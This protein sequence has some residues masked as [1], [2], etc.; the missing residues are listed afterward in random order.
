MEN[1]DSYWT[2]YYKLGQCYVAQSKW[3]DAQIIYENILK[4]DPQNSSIQESIAYIYAMNGKTQEALDLYSKIC[5][6]FPENQNAHENYISI[7]ITN[8]QIDKAQ[9][10]FE[11]YYTSGP[12]VGWNLISQIHYTDDNTYIVD[13]TKFNY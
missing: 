2:S 8:E 10:E 5:E 4:R 9:L 6:E 12:Y 13:E 1:K 7:L 3:T 11:K